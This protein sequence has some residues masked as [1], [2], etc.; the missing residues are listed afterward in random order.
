MLDTERAHRERRESEER[1]KAFMHHSPVLAF[2]KDD[3]GRYVYI[4]PEMERTFHVSLA[5]VEGKADHDWLPEH[6]AR[7]LYAGQ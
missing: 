7:R 6:L 3:E 2:M 1:L 4:N 5:D